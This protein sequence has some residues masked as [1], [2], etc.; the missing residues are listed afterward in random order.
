MSLINMLK[1][2]GPK[3]E[4][5]GTPEGKKRRRKSFKNTNLGFSVG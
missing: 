4:P 1:S 2:K 5:C 3:T